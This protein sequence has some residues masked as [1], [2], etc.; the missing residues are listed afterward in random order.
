[1]FLLTGIAL[2]LLSLLIAAIPFLDKRK[3][4]ARVVDPIRKI[5][6]NR[7]AIYQEVRAL[8]GD[9]VV[10]QVTANE[11]EDRL[12]GYR[13]QAAWLLQQEGQLTALEQQLEAGI[14]EQRGE[15]ADL[16]AAFECAECGQAIDA[17]AEECP[18]CGVSV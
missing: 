11:Y 3:A 9:F 7:E 15:E 5:R 10:G 6:G 12:Q 13:R 17:E 1:M 4:T 18:N 2:A 14:R 8:H 16:G